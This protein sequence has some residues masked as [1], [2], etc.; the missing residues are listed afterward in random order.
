MDNVD[1]TLY[2]MTTP[3]YQK[4]NIEYSTLSELP[5]LETFTKERRKNQKIKSSR[6]SL[7]YKYFDKNLEIAKST[8]CIKASTFL[9]LAMLRSKKMIRRNMRCYE[10]KYI[11]KWANVY[12]N[13][14]KSPVGC[15]YR[16]TR[17]FS[18]KYTKR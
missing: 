18:C 14:H 13:A 8:C 9:K 4:S 6:N 12:C 10:D 15:F 17:Q 2:K 3:I 11:R 5:Q 7:F 1:E 16:T